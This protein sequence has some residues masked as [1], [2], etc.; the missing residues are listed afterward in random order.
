MAANLIES[1]KHMDAALTAV[2]RPRTFSSFAPLNDFDWQLE[3]VYTRRWDGDTHLVT[4]TALVLWNGARKFSLP[5]TALPGA[6]IEYM[7]ADIAGEEDV[8]L[9]NLRESL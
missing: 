1:C 3:R 2:A 4:I 5:L 9:E 8:A 6:D 7:E